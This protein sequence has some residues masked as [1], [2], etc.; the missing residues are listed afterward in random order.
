MLAALSA[1]DDI[2]TSAVRVGS[3]VSSDYPASSPIFG[4]TFNS[5]GAC[6]GWIKSGLRLSEVPS[7]PA[8]LQ[9]GP[10]R[11][12]LVRSRTGIDPYSMNIQGGPVAVEIRT[13]ASITA[14]RRRPVCKGRP[15][16]NLQRQSMTVGRITLPPDAT[17]IARTT[18]TRRMWFAEIRPVL[19]L[20]R[21]RRE[22]H[23]RGRRSHFHRMGFGAAQNVVEASCQCGDST[24][25][26]AGSWSLRSPDSSSKQGEG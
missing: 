3:D 13:Q 14:L 21:V 4:K 5:E 10:S 16:A 15:R 7:P 26:A 12:K 25:A 1:E 18:E 9:L 23:S 2:T 6:C 22:R 17:L 8:A 19:P 11:M 20:G 24:G